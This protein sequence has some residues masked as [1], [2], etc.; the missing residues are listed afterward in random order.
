MVKTWLSFFDFPIYSRDLIIKEESVKW[1][2]FVYRRLFLSILA[3]ALSALKVAFILQRFE[4]KGGSQP[5][6]SEH[7]K[8]GPNSH[9]PRPDILKMGVDYLKYSHFKNCSVFGRHWLNFGHFMISKQ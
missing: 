9:L 5:A 2:N 3:L 6:L 1:P 8:G 4:L 7:S